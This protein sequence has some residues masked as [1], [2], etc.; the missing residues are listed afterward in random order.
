[1]PKAEIEYTSSRRKFLGHLAGGAAVVAVVCAAN[2]M[3]LSGAPMAGDPMVVPPHTVKG[4]PKCLMERSTLW[5]QAQTR[6]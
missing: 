6:N 3:A 4:M 5:L 2:Q 1:M